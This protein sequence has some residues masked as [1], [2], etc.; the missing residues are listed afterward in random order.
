M[1]SSNAKS[2]FV[3]N[4]N[5]IVYVLMTIMLMLLLLLSS[6]T[7]PYHCAHTYSCTS[8]ATSASYGLSSVVWFVHFIGNLTRIE[9]PRVPDIQREGGLNIGEYLCDYLANAQNMPS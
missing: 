6:Y 1:V 8:S 5:I 7:H 2:T 9:M 3:C 4:V